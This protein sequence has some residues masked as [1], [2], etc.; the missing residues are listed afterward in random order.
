[1]NPFIQFLIVF[2]LICFGVYFGGDIVCTALAKV[3]KK[4]GQKD[5]VKAALAMPDSKDKHRK[6]CDLMLEAEY[7]TPLWYTLK[8][9]ADRLEDAGFCWY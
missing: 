4:P 9:E 1:M 6:I 2:D 7:M 3:R 8:Q 5:P